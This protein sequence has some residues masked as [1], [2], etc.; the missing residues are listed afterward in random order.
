MGPGHVLGEKL[1]LLRHAAPDNLIIA[2]EPHAKGLAIEDLLADVG[3]DHR[4]QLGGGGRPPP[5]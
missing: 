3:L 5:L 2:I 4:V 1:H